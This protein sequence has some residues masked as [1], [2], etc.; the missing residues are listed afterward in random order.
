VLLYAVDIKTAGTLSLVVSLLTMPVALARN[1]R[2]NSFRVLRA[3]SFLFLLSAG[4]FFPFSCC[5]RGCFLR[6]AG[7]G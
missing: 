7:F 3:H 5:L 2:D 1:S 6:S 4:L